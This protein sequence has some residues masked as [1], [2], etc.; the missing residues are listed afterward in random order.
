MISLRTFIALSFILYAASVPIFAENFYNNNPNTSLY[1]ILSCLVISFLLYSGKVLLFNLVIS[2]YILK[3]YLIRPYVDI[4]HD[5]LTEKQLD[6]ILVNNSYYN[7]ADAEVVY[8]SLLSLLI[9]WML[10]LFIMKPKKSFKPFYPWVFKEIDNIISTPTWR[11]WLVFALLLILNYISVDKMWL[12][13][14][15]VESTQLFAY[16]MLETSF[17]TICCLA[18]FLYSK[19]IG[20]TKIH[21]TLFIPII[22]SVLLSMLG[23]GR[24]ALYNI[25]VIVLLY[26]SFLNF[27]RNITYKDISRFTILLLSLPIIIFT[28]LIA[29]SLKLFLKVN[30]NTTDLNFIQNLYEEVIKNIN[31]FNPEN[32]IFQSLYFGL[33]QLFYR[34]NQL[35]QP[36]LI[37][38]DRYINLP[39]ESYNPMQILMRIINDLAPG[40]L[41]PEVININRLFNHIYFD[42][43]VNY[44]SHTF[45]IQG[46]MYLLFGFVGSTIFVFIIALLIARF[47]PKISY[48]IKLS[49][50][51]FVFITYLILNIVLFGTIERVF[52][53]NFVRP[54]T[55]ILGFIFMVKTL[56]Y[57]LIKPLK[58]NFKEQ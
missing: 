11:F 39:S 43:F 8:L 35:E 20:A 7:S 2:F 37:I 42:D 26:W 18:H 58:N 40:E 52:V 47:Y 29:Q 5:K 30:S 15:G 10:G 12:S 21:L 36:F 13:L 19:N 14:K 41:F 49:P 23:G 53:V 4:L 55:S 6:F 25:I 57:F 33:T 16:G 31:I 32:P 48:L 17:I 46:T 51:F 28:G 34:L 38:N 22:I 24:G 54:L 1:L 3:Q 50:V 27:N 44:A 56:D 45:S 9:A